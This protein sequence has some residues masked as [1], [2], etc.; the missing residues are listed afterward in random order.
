LE[1]NI[2]I[3]VSDPDL[4]RT[5]PDLDPDSTGSLDP[6]LGSSGWSSKEEKK[7]KFHVKK[8]LGG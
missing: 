3:S 1:K 8:I 5:G 2:S 7:K 4:G 6:D